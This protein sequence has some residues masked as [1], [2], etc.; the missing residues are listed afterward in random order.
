M[1]FGNMLLFKLILVLRLTLDKWLESSDSQFCL[2]KMQETEI[3]P[4][5]RNGVQVTEI[6]RAFE[7]GEE[8]G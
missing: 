4:T 7:E 8:K 6:S 2:L 1:N 3:V 5:S